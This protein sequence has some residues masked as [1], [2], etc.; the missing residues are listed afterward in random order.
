MPPTPA[1]PPVPVTA[2]K[3]GK[4]KEKAKAT[5]IEV[6]N[7]KAVE[8]SAPAASDSDPDDEEGEEEG[9]P[10]LTPSLEAF[11]K[12]SLGNY[13]QS[14]QFI[15][16]HRDV[17]VPGASDALLVA[18]F[19]A[20]GEGKSKYAKQ[21]VHQSLLIQYCEKLGRDGVGIFFKKCVCS[22]TPGLP[23]SYA[24]YAIIKNGLRGQARSQSVC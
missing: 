24:L 18:G 14:F 1:P 21:C 22:S 17:Y 9:L 13:E 8:A 16:S 10:E 11:S 19:R 6:L 7:P 4:G 20:Q 2:A 3:G 23:K 15:Q 5:T 12:I